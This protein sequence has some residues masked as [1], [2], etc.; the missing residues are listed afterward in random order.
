MTVATTITMTATTERYDPSS[1]AGASAKLK[2]PWMAVFHNIDNNI[3]II[4]YDTIIY[5]IEHRY[6]K[7]KYMKL[8]D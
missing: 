3:Y 2:W 1:A 4:V 7:E 6:I 5:N 8:L